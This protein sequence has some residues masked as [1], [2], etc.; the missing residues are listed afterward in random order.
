MLC[1]G[2]VV[3]Q[4]TTAVFENKYREKIG[5]RHLPVDGFCS[6]TQTVFQVYG[7]IC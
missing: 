6:E 7:K 4:A 1:F 2:R 3:D 5:A